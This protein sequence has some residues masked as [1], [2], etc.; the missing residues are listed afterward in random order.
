MGRG[1]GGLGI[2]HDSRRGGEGERRGGGAG[3]VRGK[4]GVEGE[5]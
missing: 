2:W 1:G 3:G 5:R 4:G